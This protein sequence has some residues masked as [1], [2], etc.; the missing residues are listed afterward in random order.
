M[1]LWHFLLPTALQPR[2][3]SRVA[4]LLAH[5][6]ALLVLQ[7][8]SFAVR[9]VRAGKACDS[10][11]STSSASAG[12]AATSDCCRTRRQRRRQACR[13]R[14]AQPTCARDRACCRRRAAANRARRRAAGGPRRL[15]RIGRR[16]DAAHAHRE[17][18]ARRARGHAVVAA[19]GRRTSRHACRGVGDRA[20]FARSRRTDDSGDKR[21]RLAWPV[22]RARLASR[23]WRIAAV[24]GRCARCS[25]QQHSRT[26][27]ARSC[28][29]SVGSRRQACSS[30]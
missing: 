17:E 29:Q 4:A 15:D 28:I 9:S 21:A 7:R 6:F 24:S 14:C 1:S 23:R 11:S 10:G 27:P 30:R 3:S 26:E 19:A 12:C 25:R 2:T 20:W 16:R 8:L 5:R 18:R 22:A 13:C